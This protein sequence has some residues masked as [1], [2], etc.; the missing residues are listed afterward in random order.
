MSAVARIVRIERLEIQTAPDRITYIEGAEAI[1]ALRSFFAE[2]RAPLEANVLFRISLLK[3]SYA[4][5]TEKDRKVLDE[6]LPQY[7]TTTL[8]R[9]IESAALFESEVA[10]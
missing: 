8:S 3:D 4:S 9:L 7:F 5:L 1:N 10:S 2:D 6:Q